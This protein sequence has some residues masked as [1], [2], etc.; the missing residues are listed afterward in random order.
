MSDAVND[1]ITQ[2]EGQLRLRGIVD[3]RILAEA[4]EHLV[5]AVED[6]RRRG[7]SIDDAE[8]EALERFGPPDVVAAHI[9][10]QERERMKS[11][12]KDALALSRSANG[13]F[14]C[15]LCSPRS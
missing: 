6:G 14:S 10:L 7:L 1:Y 12:F 13:R 3:P 2:F 8:H 4:R 9:R 11:A 15:R 5:D